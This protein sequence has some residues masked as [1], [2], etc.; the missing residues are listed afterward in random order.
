MF[1][2]WKLYKYYL[3]LFIKFKN[4][5]IIITVLNKFFLL[6]YFINKGFY[7]IYMKKI[8]SLYF[9]I[10]SILAINTAM[11]TGDTRNVKEPVNP[12]SCFV[13][14]ANDKNN[15]SLI[16]SWINKCA[17][18]NKVVELKSTSDKIFHF[19]SGPL[20]IPS[21]GGLLIDKG[22]VLSAIPDPTL[23]DNGN[24]KCGTLD[25]NGRGCNPFITVNNSVNSGIYGQG[26]IDGQG[27]SIM[28]GSNKTWWNLASE[29]QKENKSQNV[30]RLIQ[31][32]NSKNFILYKIFIKNSPN[33]HV[34]LTNV[35]GFTAWGININ[36]PAD[37]RNT[38]GID[39]GSSSNVTVTHSYISTGD[40][41]IAIKAS[42]QP[43]SHI[44]IINNDFGK[45]HGMSIGSETSG[46]VNDV[47]VNNLSMNGTTSGLRIKSDISRGGLVSGIIYKNICI[48]D[49]KNPIYLDMFYNK[50]AKGNKIPEFKDINFNSV[51]VLTPGN[52]IFN[53]LKGNNIQV[54]FTNVSIKKG[55]T[56]KK[57]N[58]TIKGSI[59]ENATGNSCPIYK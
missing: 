45:G 38:D 27:N 14:K 5:V 4:Y 26:I 33:F 11:S 35:N 30:P 37:A 2:R 7:R 23:Y 56:F 19:Y 31:I 6:A 18:Q 28:K 44:S 13:L 21:N 40:D 58:V 24:H 12:A 47:L 41:N 50:N 20:N 39:P 55:S 42:N 15:T 10:M 17:K 54:T 25:N 1:I 32:R 3:K 48:K 53:G 51:K 57:V 52:F 29:A 8:N 46:K 16:Q 43:T 59:N 9:I 36:T 22:V 49:V 34:A